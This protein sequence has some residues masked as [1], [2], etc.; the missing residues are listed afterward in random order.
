MGPRVAT[1]GQGNNTAIVPR[2]GQSTASPAKDD[3]L[4]AS[5]PSTNDPTLLNAATRSRVTRTVFLALLV[6]ILSFTIILPLFPR[7]LEYYRQNESADPNSLFSVTLRQIHAFKY[8]IGGT[9]SNLDVVLFGGALGSLFSFLQ[10][11]VSPW[12]GRLSDRLGRKRVLMLC[13]AGNLASCFLWIVARPF[14][15]FVL[16]RVV[17][18]LSEGNVQLSVSIITDITTAETRSKGLALVGLAFALG[19]T[20]GP[21][22]GAYFASHDLAAYNPTFESLGLNPYSASALFAFALIL[23]EIWYLHHSLPETLPTRRKSAT[24]ATKP[25]PK[26]AALSRLALIHASYLFLFSGLEFTLPFLTHDQYQFSHAQQGALLGLIGFV[27]AGVQGGYTRRAARRVGER[28][29]VMRGLIA[30]AAGFALL[31]AW[32]DQRA[33]LYAS[34]VCIAVASAT[35]GTGL[36]SLASMHAGGERA[37]EA[38][39][40]FRAWGQLG[41]AAGPI[42]ACAS[43]WLVGATWVYGVGTLGVV[44]I[45]VYLVRAQVGGAPAK[46]QE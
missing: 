13:M 10:F 36:T 41:R 18:G 8:A 32:P 16:S 29:V 31:A 44:A 42:V 4:A 33:A 5:S 3:Q 45:A 37:G 40:A 6:D 7:L 30:C 1:T 15:V 22:M 43:Y 34:A 35:V 20:V 27:A 28:A 19:F 12:I 17:G 25:A 38:L 23:A 24:P 9:G 2:P 26:P 46:K 14:W 39:G 11:I 21:A